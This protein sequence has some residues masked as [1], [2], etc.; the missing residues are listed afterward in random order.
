MAAQVLVV[1]RQAE[2]GD[3]LGLHLRTASL[4]ARMAQRFAAEVVVRFN[5]SK[6]NGKSVMDLLCLAAGPGKVLE[7]EAHGHDAME[8]VTAL[9]ELISARGRDAESSQVA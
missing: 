5:G 1:Q 2:I 9:S 8:A 4:F 7:L 6:A 3:V